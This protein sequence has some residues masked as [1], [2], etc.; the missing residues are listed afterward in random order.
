MNL[1]ANRLCA[2]SGVAMI[3][4][5]ILGFWVIG[6]FVPPPDPSDGAQAI[7]DRYAEN[8][9]GIRVGMIISAY[10]ALLLL[11]WAAAIGTQLRRIEGR[12]G[13]WSHIQLVAA[14][15]S[16]LVFEYI[17]FFWIT[18]TYREERSPELIQLINDL[19]WLPFVGI[20]GTAILQAVAIGIAILSDPRERPILPRWVGYGNLWCALLFSP[21]AVAVF[22]KDG[23]LA[24]NGILSW[25]TVLTVFSL[26]FYLNTYAVLRALGQQEREG[27]IDDDPE[28]EVRALA[29]EVDRMREELERLAGRER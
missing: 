25:Y 3:S 26:W 6:G 12:D 18:A 13:V 10:G 9:D 28:G 1:R 29:A 8:R 7:A 17:L 5:F 24:W 16:V 27:T 11:P 19:G 14:G 23:P 2:W 21:G 22:F 4:L 15:L 20:A